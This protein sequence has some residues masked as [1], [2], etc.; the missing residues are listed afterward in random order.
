MPVLLYFFGAFRKTVI[1]GSGII[2]GDLDM[3]SFGFS[4][5]GLIYL[6]MLFVP[7]GIWA[8][9]R[10]QGYEEDAKRESKIL[11]A[12]ER[13]GEVLLTCLALIFKD[14]NIRPGSWWLGWLILSFAAM[15]LYEIYWIRYFR[16]AKTL[17]DMYSS[18][19][20]FPVAGASMPV[21]AFF[22]L[23]IYASN[24]FLIIASV[25]MGIGHIGIHMQ[26][27][28]MAGITSKKSKALKI[29]LAV[30]QVM[31]AI[32]VFIIVGISVFLVAKRNINYLSCII[33]T[34]TGID[35]QTYVD[36]HGTQ[37]FISIR[38]KD[39]TNPVI[40]F[41]HGGPMTPD[42]FLSY[43]YA[44]DLIDD[45]TFVCWD[46]RGCGRTYFANPGIAKDTISFDQ[47]LMDVE[48]MVDYLCDRFSQ[49]KIIIMGHSYGTI[50]GAR[51]VYK[52]PRKVAAYIGVGQFINAKKS[53]D[54][55][56]EDALALAK[57]A[58]DDTTYM[59][60]AYKDY[61][62]EPSVYNH[63][64]IMS[65]C[66]TYHPEQDSSDIYLAAATSPYLATDDV[67][68]HFKM[69]FPEVVQEVGIELVFTSN[70]IDL[71][72]QTD[73]KVPVYFISGANDWTCSYVLMAEYA[74]RIGADYL[75]IEGAGH[76]VQTDK[77]HEFSHAVKEFLKTI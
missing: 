27:R 53:L 49:D 44:N 70:I 32:P 51:Y 9:N 15:V 62:E 52:H 29:V 28:K 55:E 45:Y 19:A 65:Y 18:I 31:V 17:S 38:G 43:T 61:L 37:Q 21:I 66:R 54:T 10:P 39:K 26:H 59:E 16:S 40:L 77:P 3:I 35:E 34:S 14:T 8:K 25:I 11:L 4:Y 48:E 64:Q 23:G 50:L 74:D 67:R 7:N 46:Q 76:A 72:S 13:T 22:F 60:L 73:Y 12:F 30:I 58:G 41:L 56:Y 20:G 42:G 36:I 68:W 6:I 2:K 69:A 75:L 24:I 63:D 57:A 71:S 47:A 33:S 5:V 1:I